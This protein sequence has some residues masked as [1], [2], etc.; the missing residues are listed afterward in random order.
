MFPVIRRRYFSRIIDKQFVGEIA[1]D[2]NKNS[3]SP[4]IKSAW[5]DFLT[6]FQ[7]KGYFYGKW[8]I[9]RDW[10]VQQRH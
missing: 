5:N 6:Q 4:E 1:R 7:W 9:K 10:I 2:T 3:Q 8:Q